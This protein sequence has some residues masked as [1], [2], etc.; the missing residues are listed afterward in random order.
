M[1]SGRGE[2]EDSV[3]TGRPSLVNEFGPEACTVSFASVFRRRCHEGAQQKFAG[4]A[5]PLDLPGKTCNESY[6][7]ILLVQR[8]RELRGAPG[9]PEAGAKKLGSV[10]EG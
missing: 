1:P 4:F 5:T 3:I 8:G 9:I 10:I 2:A 6:R 7:V